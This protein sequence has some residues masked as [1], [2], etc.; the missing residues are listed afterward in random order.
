MGRY[1]APEFYEGKL[2]RLQ[3]LSGA[4]A[5]QADALAAEMTRYTGP[6]MTLGN[7]RQNGV[8][9]HPGELR[10][11]ARGQGECRCLA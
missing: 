4:E 8:A 10:M 1:L 7:M 9:V 5:D 6:A 11:R 3:A 2:M